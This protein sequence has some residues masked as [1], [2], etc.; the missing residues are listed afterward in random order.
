[1]NDLA[2][3][4]NPI[5]QDAPEEIPVLDL[6]PLRAGAPGALEALGAV[7]RHAF[8]NVGFY[9]IVNHGVKQDLVDRT[10]AAVR[11][12]HAQP[13]EDKLKLRINA[14]NIGYLPIRGS[15]TRHSKINEGNKP[16][17]N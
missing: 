8:E 6:G 4:L 1:M 17:L 10:F 16:N 3:R 5:R 14:H 7:L 9:F 11:Q 15:V 2:P 12:F 13:L